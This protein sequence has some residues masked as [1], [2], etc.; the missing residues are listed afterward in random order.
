MF[1][2]FSTA[3]SALDANSIAVAA[4]GNDLANLNTTGYKSTQVAFADLISQSMG[5]INGYQLGMGTARPQTIRQ[6]NQGSVQ[7]GAGTLDAAIQGQG[8]FVVNDANGGPLY[9]RDGT[10]TTDT[11]GYLVD[12]Q[13]HKVQGWMTVN[14]VLNTSGA[15]G[16]IIVS[17]GALLSPTVTKNVSLNMNLNSAASTTGTSSTFSQP[18]TVYDSLGDSHT[19]T[20]TFTKTANNSWSYTV[21]VPGSDVTSGTAGTPSSVGS[22]TL[23]FNA[24]GTLQTPAAG[25]GSIALSITGLADGA[26]DMK[27]N[28]NLYDSSGN[29]QITQ[30]DQ[31]SAVSANTQDGNGA[32]QLTAV[33]MGNG[34]QLMAQYSNGQQIAIAQ[35]ALASIRNPNSMIAIGNNDFRASS[36][37]APPVIGTASTGGRGD[38]V[39]EALEQSTVNISEEFTSLLTLQQA[40][41]A[42]SRVITSENTIL[43]ATVNLIQG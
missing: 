19:L 12:A 14:G 42:N 7:T 33:T 30:Y 37:T 31:S 22:G 6:F 5:G 26:S 1:S 39:G 16:N 43:Q 41:Q 21:T 11:N 2:T 8:F 17:T 36:V 25:S 27:V 35:L 32:A 38:I 3:L 28:W 24:D 9:T 4:V 29:P 20:F 18:M 23:T 15:T 34:G 13:G 10:F 40:Y